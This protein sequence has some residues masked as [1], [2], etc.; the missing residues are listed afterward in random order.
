MRSIV[1]MRRAAKAVAL[2]D[3]CMRLESRRLEHTVNNFTVQSFV[4]IERE[5][6][7]TDLISRKFA[8]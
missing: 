5:T 7:K 1:H 8:A 4:Y 3:E 2:D 6:P